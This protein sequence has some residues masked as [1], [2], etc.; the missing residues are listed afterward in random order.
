M[1][2][3]GGVCLLT[4]QATQPAWRFA[5]ALGNHQDSRWIRA[6]DAPYDDIL[7]LVICD[8][9]PEN[10]V[11]RKPNDTALAVWVQIAPFADAPQR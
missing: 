5:S 4:N 10:A 7:R 9:S 6:S 8:E 11:F 2:V 1:C 3:R